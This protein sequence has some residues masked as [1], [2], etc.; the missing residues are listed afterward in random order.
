M[1]WW[2]IKSASVARRSGFSIAL[3]ATSRSV[4]GMILGLTV[5]PTVLG[6]AIGGILGLILTR[7]VSTFLFD[8]EP[9]DLLTFILS[10]ACLLLATL[11]ASFVPGRNACRI[12]P[13]ETMKS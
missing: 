3:G 6:C 2:R 12:D 10:I 9:N 8:I 11:A 4:L 1:D 13:I 5:M 7:L